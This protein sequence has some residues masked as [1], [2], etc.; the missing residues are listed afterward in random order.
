[1]SKHTHYIVQ[2]SPCLFVGYDG[3]VRHIGEAMLINRVT[4][5]RR[6]FRASC[7]CVDANTPR[8]FP[9]VIKVTVETKT[10]ITRR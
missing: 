10:I 7:G 8:R 3:P 5:A 2:H 6:L 1:M 4:D 9:R